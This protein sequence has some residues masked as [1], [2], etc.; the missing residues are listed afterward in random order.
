MYIFRNGCY[1]DVEDAT[2]TGNVTA[3]TRHDKEHGP[4]REF[5]QK[6]IRPAWCAERLMPSGPLTDKAI[7][8]WRQKGYFTD[9]HREAL[10]RAREAAQSKMKHDEQFA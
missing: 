10:R 8:K 5:C 9:E 2:V 1:H 6:R 3:A 4:V 7:E